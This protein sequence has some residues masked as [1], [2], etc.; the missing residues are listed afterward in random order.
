MQISH[1]SSDLEPS[2]LLTFLL[3]PGGS[4]TRQVL[5]PAISTLWQQFSLLS[6]NQKEETGEKVF[7]SIIQDLSCVVPI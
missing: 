5:P 6:Y 1:C 2:N 4:V 7:L 3:V